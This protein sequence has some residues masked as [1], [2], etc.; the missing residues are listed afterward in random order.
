M[1]TRSK[2]VCALP[3]LL[4]ALSITS[5]TWEPVAGPIQPERVFEGPARVDRM[6]DYEG[7]FVLVL[8]GVDASARW[9]ILNSA[10]LST[11]ELPEGAQP[12]SS[13]LTA[14]NLREA[15]APAFLLPV[16]RSELGQAT[17]LFYTDEK[18][19]LRGPFGRVGTESA[20]QPRAYT[21][22][23]D[24]R[25]VST[26]VDPEGALYVVDPWGPET[27]VLAQEVRGYDSV[28]RAEAPTSE[29]DS[30]DAL[31][32]LEGG[33]KLTQRALDGTLLLS[34]GQNVRNL[35]RKLFADGERIAYRD[36]DDLYEA[37]EPSYAP[38][39][40]AKDACRPRYSNEWLD[41]WMP[42]SAEQLVRIELSTGQVKRFTQGVY[43]S[44][45]PLNGLIFEYVRA[46]DARQVWVTTRSG[47]RT[48]LVPTPLVPFNV[49]DET[50]ISG[51][52]G[53]GRF[54]LWTFASTP[55]PVAFASVFSG[56]KEI[57]T[58]RD[59]RTSQL[60][61]LMRSDLNE[62]GLG[63]LSTFTQRDVERAVAGLDA[64][65]TKTLAEQVPPGGYQLVF[66]GI[67]RE[68][69]LLSLDGA[70]R[71]AGTPVFAG[72][73]YAR[74]LSG[75]LASRIDD[76]V[77]SSKLVIAPQPGILYGI[78]EGSKSGLWFAAL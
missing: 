12:V 72:T 42:C 45:P 67:T 55:V 65:D 69:I 44:D 39:L 22:R 64:P 57:S 61:W 63:R 21:L 56:V 62:Q 32:V 6:L 75:S 43:A 16:L 58:Y 73:L 24:G 50:R 37:K 10:T 68:P 54:G 36:G 15:D 48:Q 9:R 4:A 7:R 74:L 5:C 66:A 77:S 33:G 20:Q 17:Q 11:C 30:P 13:P 2:A 19:Q 1:F 29:R 47:L 49:L 59:S 18:C 3:W 71:Q 41:F 25:A 78:T 53:D 27:H 52:T 14:P 31:W 26:V 34:L 38:V 60:L 23:T 76:G 70:V 28:E 40:I 35:Q 51:V 46:G 8:A